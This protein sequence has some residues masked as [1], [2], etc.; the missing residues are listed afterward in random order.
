M[1]KTDLKKYLAGLCVL[2]LLSGATL[3]TIGCQKE[4]TSS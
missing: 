3:G 4:G 2:G 1:D